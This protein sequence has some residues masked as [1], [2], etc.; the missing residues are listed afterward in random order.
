MPFA[1][2]VPANARTLCAARTTRPGVVAELAAQRRRPASLLGST[3]RLMVVA[4][5]HPARGAL[6]AG[7]RELA[8][9]DRG[10]LLDRICVALSR[11][12]VNG[13]LGT[14]DVLEDLL[15]LGA[16]DDKVVIGSMNRGGIAGACFEIDDRPTGYDPAHLAA[17]GFDAGKMLVR[18]D[19]ED[20]Q[21]VSTLET[22]ARTVT[23][24]A[25]RGLMALVEPFFTRRVD[26]RLVNDL[27]TDAVVRAVT[28]AAGWAAPRPTPGSSCRSPTTWPGWRPCWPPRTCPWCCS[29]ARC[30]MTRDPP[31]EPS[32][33]CSSCPRLPDWSSVVPC[34]I[35]RT[36]TWPARSTGSWAC[37]EARQLHRPMHRRPHRQLHRPATDPPL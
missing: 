14:A 3:G 8:M 27:S 13:V 5:D 10:D 25:D 34:C 19:L 33:G 9:A 7:D 36:T 11:P 16:L 21:S 2:P 17:M 32:S 30:P 28:V 15:L 12:E 37:C 35:R 1:V 6:G 29:V 31:C 24:L 22:C 26:G 20:R 18:I 4:A 23:E